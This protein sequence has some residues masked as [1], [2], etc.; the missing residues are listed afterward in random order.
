MFSLIVLI[1]VIDCFLLSSQASCP[2][3][4]TIP[5]VTSL[6]RALAGSQ[7]GLTTSRSKVHR[8]VEILVKRSFFWPF[9]NPL[10]A[11]RDTSIP[12]VQ[13]VRVIM[14]MAITT[15]RLLQLY[16]G[17]VR[18]LSYELRQ[19]ILICSLSQQLCIF[20]QQGNIL[21]LIVQRI[22]FH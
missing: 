19:I 17:F 16:M 13:K 7:G 12:F 21:R 18:I 2:M 3:L 14:V 11:V 1:L 15:R 6:C 20:I 9:L 8:G 10:L 5:V 22:Q 4:Q